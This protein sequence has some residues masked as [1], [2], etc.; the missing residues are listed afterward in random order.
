[1]NRLLSSAFLIATMALLPAVAPAQSRGYAPGMDAR[2]EAPKLPG[3][4]LQ[5]PLHSASAPV[6]LQLNAEQTRA[7]AQ[8]YDSFMVATQPQRDSAAAAIKK[9]NER[10]E[11]GDRAAALFYVERLNEVG[12]RLKD[13]QDRFEDNLKKFLTGDQ[14]KA[15]RQWRENEQQAIERKQREDAVK[16]VEAAFVGFGGRPAGADAPEIKAP[17]PPAPGVAAPGLGAQALRVG[18]ALYVTGQLGTDSTGTL[19]GTDLRTQAVQAFANLTAVLRAGG[20]APRNVVSLTILVVNY[21]PADDATI[22]EVGAA[23]LTTNAPVVT[24]AGVQSLAREGALI[25][26]AATAATTGASFTRQP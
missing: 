21:R 20:A 17:V 10:L 2:S 13:R 24:I 11:V 7:Y 6:V 18:R 22:R 12:K 1:M 3:I 8:A 15:Y 4:E 23:Y 5:G 16:W 19:V 25:S 26:V 14:V 9:M